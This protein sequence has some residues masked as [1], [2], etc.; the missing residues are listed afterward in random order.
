LRQ[1]P[2]AAVAEF[3][4]QR[5]DVAPEQAGW[6]AAASQG[7]VE[8]ARQLAGDPEARDRRAEVLSV[9]RRLTS[10]GAC[11]DVAA[12]LEAATKLEAAS[13]VAELDVAERTALERA[14]GAGGTGRGATGAMRGA[15]GQ[16]KE[17]ER[18]QKLRATRAQRDALDRA[19]QDLIGFYRDVL[20]TSMRAP[21]PVVHGDLQAVSSAAAEKW[22]PESTL[23]RME[24]VL[25]CRDAIDKNVKPQ[26]ALE[27]MMVTLWKG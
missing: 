20:V 12:K 13:A 25:A 18:N 9:P 22:S 23:R 4:V 7:D 26:V 5:F 21:V 24:A 3:L 1:P 10:I 15:A 6:A 11:F 8:R 17:L 2:S 14:L 16:L 19:L 27:A